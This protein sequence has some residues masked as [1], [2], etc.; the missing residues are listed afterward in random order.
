[1][2][3]IEEQLIKSFLKVKKKDYSLLKS[4]KRANFEKK[5]Q[6][7]TQEEPFGTSSAEF[8]N[9][10]ALTVFIDKK[11][12]F[13]TKNYFLLWLRIEDYLGSKGT[14]ALA[15]KK[16]DQVEEILKIL[17]KNITPE[18]KAN[19]TAMLPKKLANAQFIK[20]IYLTNDEALSTL[21][22]KYLPAPRASVFKGQAMPEMIAKR[23]Q[24]STQAIRDLLARAPNKLASIEKKLVTVQRLFR[25][26]RRKQENLQ[27][28]TNGCHDIPLAKIP[29][30]PMEEA[31]ALLADA[32]K[33]YR[34][35]CEE[36]LAN[37]IMQ[38]AKKV[39][40]FSTVR[41][42]TAPSALESIF[43]DGLLGRRTLLQSYI[44]FKPAALDDGDI[45]NGD[46]NVVCLGP[47]EITPTAARGGIELQF[48]MKKV[49]ENNPC[50]FYKQKDLGYPLIR[51]RRV[52]IGDCHLHFSHTVY[53]P[54]TGVS[55]LVLFRD[56]R[57][58]LGRGCARS[59]VRNISLIADNVTK[60][61][62]I[63]TLNFFR[64]VDGLTQFHRTS[65]YQYEDD[66]K[67]EKNTYYNKKIYL[68]LS[69]LSD[70]EL[71]ET[72]Q[73]IGKSMT[74]TM[75][76]NLYGAYRI[77]FSALLAIKNNH[78]AYT[79]D[80]PSF[81]NELNVGNLGKLNE[82]K[83]KLPEIFNSYRF[84]DYLLSTTANEI[85]IAE[86]KGLRQKCTLPN[87]MEGLKQDVHLDS[88]YAGSK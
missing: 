74:D 5:L 25:A 22:L 14:I 75:E 27:R 76:F 86:L 72:L 58:N 71:I 24:D 69:K 39:E 45:N 79:L 73:R 44:F 84:V 38:A 48:D 3:P 28:L 34:P 64:F 46:A 81:I 56:D 4:K 50:V 68:E 9:H 87:W 85:V 11:T 57:H 54:Q 53:P 82:A 55:S 32:N 65:C 12:Y 47:N 59:F 52:S 41:H 33:P 7:L 13:E 20:N 63:L 29:G 37:R 17:L 21:F 15:K 36:K 83:V 35:Q 88:A 80:L 19:G 43:N 6:Q 77:D 8:R 23:E 66:Y 10:P 61:H 67:N 51:M 78:L 26:K 40:L 42:L 2:K 62:R 16:L 18:T 30:M 31:K 1:M 60:M 70:Q 49:V